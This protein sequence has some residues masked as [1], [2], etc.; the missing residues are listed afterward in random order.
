MG[1]DSRRDFLFSMAALCLPTLDGAAPQNL[2]GSPDRREKRPRG[3]RSEL[4]RVLGVMPPRPRPTFVTLESTKLGTGWRHKIE[5]AAEP[6][7]PIFQTPPDLIRAY[8]FVPDHSENQKLPA[9]LAIHQDGPQSHIGKSEPAGL[10]GD[11]NLFY[12]LELFEKG[13]VVL[14]R[15]IWTRRAP[16]G[17]AERHYV[18][19]SGTRPRS[20]ESSLR[21]APA[22]RA[23]FHW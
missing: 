9:V 19:R 6:A 11:K 10:A 22:E 2:H 1:E 15:S 3:Q 12:G 18:D 5:F 7:N 17:Y 23:Q 14:C 16:L 8:L 4:D 13:Y 21:S 20:L